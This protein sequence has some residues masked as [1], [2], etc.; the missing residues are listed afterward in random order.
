MIVDHYFTRRAITTQE[1]ALLDAL[2]TNI[3]ITMEN[4]RLYHLQDEQL[5]KNIFE[6]QVLEQIDRELNKNLDLEYVYEVL[7]DWAM[8]FTRA[9]VAILTEVDDTN[10]SIV[11][12]FGP[13]QDHLPVSLNQSVTLDDL[14]NIGKVAQTTQPIQTTETFLPDGN[15]HISV[16]IVSR[17]VTLGVVTVEA[18]RDFAEDTV[19]FMER[20][21][22]RA[23]VAMEN[24][25]LYTDSSS[26]RKQLSAILNNTA[27]AVLVIS[28]RQ[29]VSLLN[30][31]ALNLFKLSQPA[32][33]YEGMNFNDVFSS[34]S[35]ASLYWNF[36]GE[37]FYSEEL[38]IGSS[39]YQA[40]VT[41]V[42]N[43]GH[44]ILLHD[45]TLFKEVDKLK[46]ELVST[47]SH[48]LKNPLSVVNGYVEMLSM[49]N[50]FD[51]KGQRYIERIR[52]SIDRMQHLIDDLLDLAKIDAGI[53]LKLTSVSMPDL[54]H[55]TI[56][57]LQIRANEKNIVV[58]AEIAPGLPSVLA[59][60]WR[61]Q[62]V[63]TN[64]LSN[65][66]KYTLDGGTVT[67][68]ARQEGGIVRVEVK[69]TGIG[70]PPDQLQMVWERFERI[71]DSRTANIDG[72]GLGL[73]IVKRIVEAHSGT[74][75][76][77]SVENEGS[78]FWFTIPVA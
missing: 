58:R 16:P 5:Q 62:Q 10:G 43:I 76:V 33:Y 22:A 54:I 19:K 39:T 29:T 1:R 72:S 38:T 30:Q 67:I 64:L 44:I 23:A 28:D 65:G 53:Q 47:V 12:F 9:Q 34:S 35:I 36:Q 60:D 78:T 57:E 3:A 46:D 63:I 4:A 25:R 48:D 20:L 41:G 31:A 61:L 71:R 40:S 49:T 51:E 17:D 66:I 37:G 15:A 2:A 52:I 73:A 27:D 59:E 32:I 6:L 69:D 70:I 11:Y 68:H 26:R 21:A 45:V 13:V 77:T 14:G 50:D 18:T 8:R 56:D 24:A 7:L 75:G 42:R 74:V 55:N